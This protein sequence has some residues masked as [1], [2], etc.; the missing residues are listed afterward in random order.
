MCAP[1]AIQSFQGRVAIL[2]P[3][4]KRLPARITVA[5]RAAKLVVGLPTDD[6]WRLGIM[7]CQ[8]LGDPLRELAVDFGRKAIVLAHAPYYS[9]AILVHRHYIWIFLGYPGRHCR[10]WRTQDSG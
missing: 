9:L 2:K 10:G 4:L 8:G 7:L 6:I 1:G 5:N 3:F